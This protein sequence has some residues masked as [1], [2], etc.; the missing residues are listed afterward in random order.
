[1]N[2]TYKLSLPLIEMST[3]SEH[4]RQ[5]LEKAKLQF[6]MIPNMYKAMVNNHSLLDTYMY[7][8]Q[9]FRSNSGFT[10]VEQEVVF[11]TISAENGC[12]YC[13]GAHSI[14]ADMVSAVPVDVTNA[15]RNN[16]EISDVKLR[17]LSAFTAILVRKRGNPTTEDA[18]SFM[19]AGY[20]EYHMLSIILALS[21]KTISNYT[22]HLFH[23]ELDA[24]F[25]TREWAGYKMMR[26]VVNYFKGK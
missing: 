20:T 13:V 18:T 7:G 2:T 4:Q 19:N 14:I 22:N 17:A 6:K 25:K 10:P 11:L 16:T 23:T 21:I 15:I 26:S 9:L 8:Y 1:M 5:L 3:A 12:D 24:P